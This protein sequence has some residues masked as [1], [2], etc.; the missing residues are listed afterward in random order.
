[1]HY[2]D[3]KCLAFLRIWKGTEEH[4]SYPCISDRFS[5]TFADFSRLSIY[6]MHALG[7]WSILYPELLP[8]FKGENGLPVI[9]SQHLLWLPTREQCLAVVGPAQ[10]VLPSMYPSVGSCALSLHTDLTCTRERRQGEK[11]VFFCLIWA[12]CTTTAA[13]HAQRLQNLSEQKWKEGEL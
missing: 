12:H 13:P 7:G 2:W 1:M 3:H 9:A 6:H 11:R 8:N 10:F 4:Q 5:V